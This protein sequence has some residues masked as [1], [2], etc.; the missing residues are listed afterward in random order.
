M[1]S[2]GGRIK[3]TYFHAESLG[4][5]SDFVDLLKG[6]VTDI[7]NLTPGAFPT[8][9]DVESYPNLPM[10]GIGSR[11]AGMDVFWSLYTKGYFTDLVNYKVLAF[12]PTPPMNLWLKKK[13]T[14]VADLKGWKIRG[15]DAPSRKFID[16]IGGVGT[17]MLSSDAYMALDRGTLDGIL[18]ADEQV[19]G[20]KLYEVVK[21]AV[22]QPK[23]TIGCTFFLMTK[24]TWDKFP[25]D[26]QDGIDKAVEANK[27]AF[28]ASVK[29]ADASYPDKLKQQGM[30]LSSFS[31]EE[32][33]KL[34]TLAAP[35]KTDW[36][37]AHPA[38]GKDIAA[39]VD[40]VLAKYK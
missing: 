30:D 7:V 21:N 33:A 38:V 25:K 11:A 2:T 36:I 40:T 9:F 6:G 15:G 31:P 26:V 37:A 34:V 14:T 4:K 5:A 27:A 28:L 24:A 8:Q 1:D 32:T 17:S 10:I 13:A 20:T 22:Y 12:E 35:L 29:D 23:T 18:T 16:L 3:I 19:Y 39:L